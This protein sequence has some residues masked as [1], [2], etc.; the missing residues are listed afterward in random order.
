MQ[1][2]QVSRPLN[3]YRRPLLSCW[4]A[5]IAIP[6]AHAGPTYQSGRIS[7]VTFGEESPGIML[8]GDPADNCS[9]VSNAWTKVPP[10]SIRSIPPD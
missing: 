4:L 10:S 8:G 2:F 3:S 5:F 1:N 6:G 7:N 9:C